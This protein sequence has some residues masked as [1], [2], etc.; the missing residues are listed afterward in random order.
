MEH[1]TTQ[2]VGLYE[3]WVEHGTTQEVG[4]YEG[5]MEYGTTQQM[6]VYE[7]WVGHGM[8]RQVGVYEGWVEHGTTRQVGVYERWAG[9]D[10]CTSPLQDTQNG[11]EAT[12]TLSDVGKYKRDNSIYE[13]R[14]CWTLNSYHGNININSCS[15]Y[16]GSV[17]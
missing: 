4:L 13:F 1:G 2:E 5:W 17:K 15:H 14:V 16:Q 10:Y 12:G 8:T 9:H 6:G 11:S 3:G 7:G